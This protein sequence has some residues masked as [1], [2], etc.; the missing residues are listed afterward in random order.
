[1]DG[2]VAARVDAVL[3]SAVGT[4]YVVNGRQRGV[5]LDCRTSLVWFLDTMHRRAEPT[6]IPTVAPDVALHDV[7]TAARVVKVLIDS[8]G[9]VNVTDERTIEPGDLIGIR[10]Y[11]DGHKVPAHG[12]IAGAKPMVAYHAPMQGSAFKK[13]GI[14]SGLDIVCVYRDPKKARW[15]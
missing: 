5:A 11:R 14:G 8:F 3:E 2:A 4:P 6:A 1:V 9:L 15:A 10:E 13:F 12:M 7:H